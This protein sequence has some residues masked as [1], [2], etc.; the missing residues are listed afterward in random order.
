MGYYIQTPGLSGKAAYLRE[1]HGAIAVE[2]VEPSALPPDRAIVCVVANG[3][4]DAAG[5]CFDDAEFAA[6]ALPDGRKREW[7]LMDRATVE[8]LSNYP[9]GD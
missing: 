1:H 6:F 4:Y 2:P 8:R 3:A 5:Y 7:L 9:H